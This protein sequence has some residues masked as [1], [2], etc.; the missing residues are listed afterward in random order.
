VKVLWALLSENSII[1]GRT[2]NLSLVEVIEELTIPA[3]PPQGADVTGEVPSTHL[4]SWL[5]V[6]FARSDPQMGEEGRSQVSMV[7]PSG[8]EAQLLDIN[9]DLTQYPRSRSVIRLISFPLPLSEEG[10]YAF[11]VEIIS[12]HGT[13]EE[14]FEVPLQINIQKD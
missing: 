6:L 13:W 9:V 10:E 14:A 2:N 11:K 8:R 12:D 4:N 3:Q 1:N 5:S 7:S